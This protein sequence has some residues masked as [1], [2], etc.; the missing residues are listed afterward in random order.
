MTLEIIAPSREE[1]GNVL[2]VVYDPPTA[3]EPLRA[4]SQIQGHGLLVNYGQFGPEL[5][6]TN[7]AGTRDLPS[8]TNE[9]PR[10]CSITVPRFRPFPTLQPTL[11]IPYDLLFRVLNLNDQRALSSV[12]RRLHLGR[13]FNRGT[14]ITFLH[15]SCVLGASADRW[16]RRRPTAIT[17]NRQPSKC[18]R[19]LV[20]VIHF[21]SR[22]D[23]VHVIGNSL[24]SYV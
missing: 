13:R 18:S 16:R 22:G 2:F 11:S 20:R 12:H 4:R 5:P 10:P 17:S 21:A 24:C 14:D 3:Q 1:D 23:T 6:Q 15:R 19:N 9:S 7:V 8:D